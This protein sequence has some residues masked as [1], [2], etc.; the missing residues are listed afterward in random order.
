ME[1]TPNMFASNETP[2]AHDPTLEIRPL[3]IV[4]NVH[5]SEALSATEGHMGN[6]AKLL[7]ISRRSLYRW[8]H[9]FGVDYGWG[10]SQT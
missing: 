6:A 8:R 5:I 9:K 2:R 7:G 10:M 1:T 3:Q 4:I